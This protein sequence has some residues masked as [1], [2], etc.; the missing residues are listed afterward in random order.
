M[1][2]CSS[3]GHVQNSLVNSASGTVTGFLPQFP[4]YTDAASFVDSPQ[5]S[6]R[7]HLKAK[8]KSSV[9]P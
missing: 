3:G 2:W 6:V 9:N 5:S 8:G 7:S 4:A 1:P